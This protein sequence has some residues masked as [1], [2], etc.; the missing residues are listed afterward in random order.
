MTLVVQVNG[1]VRDRIAVPAGIGEDEATA[2]ALASEKVAP[3]PARAGP[4]PGWWPG[5]RTWSTS[6]CRDGVSRGGIGGG[7]G[8]GRWRVG[9]AVAAFGA[10]VL[11]SVAAGRRRLVRGSDRLRVLCRGGRR[12]DAGHHRRGRLAGPGPR[13]GRCSACGPR[14]RR[15]RLAAPRGAVWRWPSPGPPMSVIQRSSAATPPVQSVVQSAGEA[16]GPAARWA[17]VIVSV[18]LAPISE[19]L[20]FR[21]VLLAAVRAP[22]LRPLGRG[23][24]RRGLRPDAPGP[25]LRTP[26]RRCPPCS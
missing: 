8:R 13:G 14:L 9:H 11:A 24:H 7:A 25:G 26:P 18:L 4:R 16:E 3:V 23:G 1:K 5:R 17:V 22:S 6:S 10:G 19:E 12:P 20:V 15:L 2:L 21:G